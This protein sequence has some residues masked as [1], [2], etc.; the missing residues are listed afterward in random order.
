MYEDNI[1]NTN[2][3][4][5]WGNDNQTVFYTTKDGALR[6]YCIFRHTLGTPVEQDI[7]VYQEKDPMF[8]TFI[9][10]TKS[11]KNKDLNAEYFKSKK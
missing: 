6:D 10:K 5:V 3:S 1:P 8:Y 7:L 9:Y 2:G 4:V 11:K